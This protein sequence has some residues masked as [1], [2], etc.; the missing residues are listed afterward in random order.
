[1][2]VLVT[3]GAGFIGSH[4]ARACL[5][6]GDAVRVLDDFSTGRRDNLADV[7]RDVDVIEGGV[8]DLAGVRAAVSGCEV[9]F[10][11]AAVV[12]VPLSVQDP[13]RAHAVNAL[14][15]LHVL[16]AARDAG[17]RRVVFAGTCAAYG[18]DPQLPKTEDMPTR[19]LSPYAIQKLAAEHYCQ[20][21]TAL[22][23]LETV[24]L[25]YFN[26]FGPRQDASSSYAGVIPLFVSALVRGRQPVIFGDGLQT[27]DFVHVSDVVRA[28][29]MAASSPA[30]AGLVLNVGRGEAVTVRALY[31]AIAR[32]LG[33]EGIRPA[34]APER[35]GDIRHSLAD[36]SRARRVLGWSAQVGLAEG[37]RDTV[38]WYREA[39]R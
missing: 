12:S 35:P 10:H 31:D 14:G 13:L 1:V 33:A 27:R 22:Y 3:G 20:R 7:E 17:V 8:E 19:P 2:K 23:G 36:A 9:V 6:A 29:R 18:D 4:I 21:F 38:A 5:S 34:S 37:L 28:N 24:V 26:V 11:Q 39:A 32:E 25:R 30:A 16:L 15:T